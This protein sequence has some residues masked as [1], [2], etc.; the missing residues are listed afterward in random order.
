M[1]KFHNYSYASAAV[2]TNL[3][4]PKHENDVLTF[5]GFKNPKFGDRL[6]EDYYKQVLSQDDFLIKFEPES[7]KFL[8]V[9]NSFL[10]NK[11]IQSNVRFEVVRD[12][13][14]LWVLINQDIFKYWGYF[15]SDCPVELGYYDM[16]IVEEESNRVIYKNTI[17]L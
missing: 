5:H 10:G 15:I 14:V 4:L 12:N 17:K 11:N 2:S 9:K 6:K 1:E 7:N 16:R 8:W 3:V 13:Q